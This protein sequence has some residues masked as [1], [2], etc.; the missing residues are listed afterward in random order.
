MNK[1]MSEWMSIQEKND[2]DERLLDAPKR[3]DYAT[4][5]LA[6]LQEVRQF[7]VC[8]HGELPG[9]CKQCERELDELGGL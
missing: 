7:K 4:V 6:L 9:R 8:E 2:E 1:W 3:R 5:L